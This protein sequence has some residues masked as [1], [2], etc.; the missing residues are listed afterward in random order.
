MADRKLIRVR[1][2]DKHLQELIPE[3]DGHKCIV[4]ERNVFAQLRI[5]WQKQCAGRCDDNPEEGIGT[6]RVGERLDNI[7]RLTS[8]GQADDDKFAAQS[9][10]HH[11]DPQRY[12]ALRYADDFA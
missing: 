1:G 8:V 12:G 11:S 6:R 9:L 3:G 4:S 5:I 2:V 7:S 10:Q